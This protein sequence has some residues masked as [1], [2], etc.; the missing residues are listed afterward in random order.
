MLFYIKPD[1]VIITETKLNKDINTAEVLPSDLGYTVYR[2][3]RCD[4]GGGGVALLI[5]SQYA[6]T[7]VT[8]AG[9]DKKSELIWVEVE[10]QSKKKLLFSSF[11]RRPNEHSTS[12]LE[13]L[14]Y[15]RLCSLLCQ[16]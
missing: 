5:N 12:Q 13:A 10:Q 1:A 7:E 8:P 9:T 6:S 3:D 11:Y 15:M 4:E 16:P 2:R 14:H